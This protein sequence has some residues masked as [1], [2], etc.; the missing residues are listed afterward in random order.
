MRSVNVNSD[1]EIK[2]SSTSEHSLQSFGDSP[3]AA[4]PTSAS[5]QAQIVVYVGGLDDEE[6]HQVPEDLHN[7]IEEC[8][9]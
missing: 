5:T 6:T 8:S 2:F 1:D 7:A 9:V 3:E 4:T